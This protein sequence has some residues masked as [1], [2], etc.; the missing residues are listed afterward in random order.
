MGYCAANA[1]VFDHE[2]KAYLTAFAMLNSDAH[3]KAV[4]KKMTKEDFVRNVPGVNR[5]L[6]EGIYTRVTAREIVL[7]SLEGIVHAEGR[8]RSLTD[9]IV[10]VG[11]SDFNVILNTLRKSGA[12]NRDCAVS[13]QDN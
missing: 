11:Q 12:R 2:D 10:E 1:G 3:S 9:S 7:S 13:E 4:K 8:E 6:L 5:E